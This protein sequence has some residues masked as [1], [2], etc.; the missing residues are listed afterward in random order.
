MSDELGKISNDILYDN[1]IYYPTK[2]FLTGLVVASGR[3][4]IAFYNKY[5]CNHKSYD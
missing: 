1:N 2:V 3:R 5:L 4:I